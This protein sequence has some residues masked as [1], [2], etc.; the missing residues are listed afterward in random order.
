MF[1]NTRSRNVLYFHTRLLKAKHVEQLYFTQNITKHEANHT[2]SRVQD[3]AE[4]VQVP[5]NARQKLL[6]QLW[7]SR[8]SCGQATAEPSH[9]GVTAEKTFST[10]L[11][12]SDDNCRRLCVLGSQS[13][14]SEERSTRLK[15]ACFWPV[16]KR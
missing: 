8:T 4:I 1:T 14:R 16:A 7:L 11:I 3:M 10:I 2:S 6:V 9:P 15:H 12:V 5:S 13:C